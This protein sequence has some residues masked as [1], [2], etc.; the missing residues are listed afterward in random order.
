MTLDLSMTPSLGLEVSPALV[1]F[2]ELLVLPYGA[3]SALVDEELADNPSL[4]RLEP[5]ECPLCRGRAPRR[6]PA[7]ASRAGAAPERTS[8]PASGIE[9]PQV[10]SD[11][12]ALRRAVRL[13]VRRDE[14]AVADHLVD[15]LDEHGLL[16]RSPAELAG[17]LGVA[18]AT[19]LRV[20]AVVRRTG[21]PG[22][23]ATSAGDCLRLQL[24]ALG[25]DTPVTALARRVVADHLPAL[26]RGHLAAVAAATGTTRSQ[27]EEVLDLV[28]RRLR[29]HPAYDGRV[30]APTTYVVPDVV[31]RA[32]DEPG[33]PFT[34]DLV[35]PALLRLGPRTDRGGA[36]DGLRR[37]RAFVT[38]LHDRW[39]TLRRV[40]EHAV[41]R[42]SAFLRAGPSALAPLTRAEVAQALDLHEST[43]SRAVAD[44]TVL[45]PDRSLI[46]LSC[47]FGS[48]GALDAELRRLVEHAPAVLSDQ[49]L[50]EL[51]T[52][53][54]FPVA[55][56][57]VAKHRARLGLGSTLLR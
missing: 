14:T 28:R 1:A 10:E 53:A 8:S 21:P 7:C 18:E 38:Q 44:K 6:C 34:V 17:E 26:A 5:A 39:D 50:A 35:E 32:A 29:P 13:E 12:S 52:E 16:D 43:V 2:A 31:V 20:L 27:V 51:L 55:R 49:R 47:L 42:Q 40:A 15:S 46:P 3:M 45:L 57:T 24:D 54:G 19:V 33:G 48:A 9:V 36:D 37:A 41:E 4:T 30:P 11:A 23:G 56:R 25:E 22:V